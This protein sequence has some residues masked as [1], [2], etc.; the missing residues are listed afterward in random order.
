KEAELESSSNPFAAVVLA[1]AKMLET[2]DAAR[3]RWE[4]KVRLF[5]GLYE[6]GSRREVIYQLF[7]LLDWMLALPEEQEQSFHEEMHRFEEERQVPYVTSFERRALEKGREEGREE[8][9]RAELLDGISEDLEERFGTE[10]AKVLRRVR[11]I[12]DVAQLRLL[13]KEIRS[14]TSLSRVRALVGEAKS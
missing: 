2:R 12:K 11:A 10:G 4:W 6:R 9:R 8:G 14:A 5:K 1:Q 13:G 3:T 7:R